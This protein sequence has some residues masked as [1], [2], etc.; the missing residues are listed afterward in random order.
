MDDD[1]GS[2]GGGDGDGDDDNNDDSSFGFW[3]QGFFVCLEL[4]P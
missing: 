2:A 3:R 1:H 4:T